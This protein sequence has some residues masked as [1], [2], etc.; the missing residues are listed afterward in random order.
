MT[1]QGTLYLGILSVVGLYILGRQLKG[2][3]IQRD[4]YL[5]PGLPHSSRVALGSLP[6]LSEPP[7]S[8]LKNIT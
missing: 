2:S 1:R 6:S 8:H 7:V 3:L 4:G 5:H